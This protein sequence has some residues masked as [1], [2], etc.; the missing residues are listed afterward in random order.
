MQGLAAMPK[1]KGPHTLDRQLE[2]RNV[3]QLLLPV[4]NLRI[5]HMSLQPLS[6]PAR[7]VSVLHRQ[8]RQ[9][10]LPVSFEGSVEQ[11]QLTQEHTYGPAIAD[12]VVHVQKQPVLLLVQAQQLSPNKRPI[13]EL[14]RTCR[15]LSGEPFCLGLSLFDIQS[16]E[17]GNWTVQVQFARDY[18]DR[19]KSV[20]C[21][22]GA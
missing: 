12:N 4:S 6:L 8:R 22:G 5:E 11:T 7:V 16:A 9:R 20:I 21:K 10:R 14:K 13:L 17:I 19:F 18:L 3:G 15:V 1:H 2:N